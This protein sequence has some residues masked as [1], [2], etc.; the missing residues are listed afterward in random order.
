MNI[1]YT[2][3]VNR[4]LY[5]LSARE[6]YN[7]WVTDKYFYYCISKCSY[8]KNIYLKQISKEEY[9]TV[10]AIKYYKES[11]D[12][13]KALKNSML[14]DHEIMFQ[15]LLTK[16]SNDIVIKLIEVA[17]LLNKKDYCILLME[18]CSKLENIYFD[19][20]IFDALVK[21]L[22]YVDIFMSHRKTIPKNLLLAIHRIASVEILKL[23]VEKY[24]V[25]NIVV[26]T[27]ILRELLEKKNYI[28]YLSNYLE[29]LS[30]MRLRELEK[31]N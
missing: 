13:D 4:I 23:L 8:V 2:D 26:K 6:I 17:I 1:L 27:K 15:K 30:L 12:V 3:I 7:L 21:D 31:R 19:N 5:F 28:S 18:K 25:K 14:R 9:N 29:K 20:N 16:A 22:Y 24:G 10:A 11:K